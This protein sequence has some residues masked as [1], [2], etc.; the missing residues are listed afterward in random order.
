MKRDG[1]D[2]GIFVGFGFSRDAEKE[3]RRIERE[4]GLIIKMVTV[5]ELIQKQMNGTYQIKSS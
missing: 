4:D 1:R 2:K 3:I 5:E